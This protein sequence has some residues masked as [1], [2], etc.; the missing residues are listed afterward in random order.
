MAYTLYRPVLKN[1]NEFNTDEILGYE[2]RYY[3]SSINNNFLFDHPIEIHDRKTLN[4]FINKSVIDIASLKK[5]LGMI[6]IGDLLL[7][8]L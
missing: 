1:E 7:L 3:Y 6:V 5:L 2:I 8:T 4:E